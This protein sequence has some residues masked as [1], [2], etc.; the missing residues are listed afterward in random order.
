MKKI[1]KKYALIYSFI[2]IFITGCGNQN[3]TKDLNGMFSTNIFQIVEASDYNTSEKLQSIKNS[4]SSF[5]DN[6][7]KPEDRLMIDYPFR[8]SLENYSL[9]LLPINGTEDEYKL[10]L[11]DSNTIIQE[12]PCGKISGTP[13]FS[14]DD[15]YSGKDLE[16]FFYDEEI[17]EWTGLLFQWDWNK[18]DRF[19]EN[20][21]RIPKYDE[22][23]NATRKGLVSV[24]DENDS[25]MENTLY[26]ISDDIESA[27]EIRKWIFEKDTKSL[28]IYDCLEDKIIFEGKVTLDKDNNIVDEEYYQCLFLYEIPTIR[29]FEGNE[30]I[31]VTNADDI[32]NGETYS[33]KQEFLSHYGFDKEEEPFYQCYD[34]LGNLIIELYFDE[35]TGTGCGIRYDAF[36]NSDL[37]KKATMSGFSFSSV[38]NG[39]WTTPETYVLKPWYVDGE[40]NVKDI[41]GIENYEETVEYLKDGRPDYFQSQGIIGWLGNDDSS[42]EIYTIMTI[43]F[44]YRNDGTLFYKYYSHN[45]YVFATANCTMHIYYDE[46]ERI[47][48]ESDYITHGHIEHYYIYK[49]NSN[50]P[51]YCLSLDYSS[52]YI[53]FFTKYE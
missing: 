28:K 26:E 49:N 38:K 21:I 35:K 8:N 25:V 40:I 15:V 11:Y 30:K 48:Y 47:K 43:N 37:E 50:K 9:Y 45:P 44:I 18:D 19:I 3:K 24:I 32:S 33:N 46:L 10:V 34:V 13:E 14:F 4:T 42:N 31:D 2:I 53:P 41:D 23:L 51:S 1:I 12:L 16:I 17:N 22:V 6:Y 27:I 29:D 7:I 5:M 52:S 39:K 20:F 36:Y